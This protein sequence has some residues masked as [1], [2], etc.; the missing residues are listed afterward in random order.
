MHQAAM[1]KR[2]DKV[3]QK[4][5]VFL[6]GPPGSGKS[7][8][9]KKL[10]EQLGLPFYDLDDLIVARRAMSIEDIFTIF[11]EAEFRRIE[12]EVLQTT[13]AQTPG[14]VALGGGALLW[15]ANR[16]AA[17]FYGEVICLKAQPEIL[18][19]RIAHDGRIRPLLEGESKQQALS[20]L[21]HKRAS[22]YASFPL[23]LDTSH[24]PLESVVWHCQTLLGR[25]Y[26]RGMQREYEVRVTSGGLKTLGKLLQEH[27]L[28][29]PLAVVTDEHVAQIYAQETSE[30]L[31]GYGY[32]PEMVILPPGEEHKS[33]RSLQEVWQALVDMHMERWGTIVSL[34]GGVINDLAGFAAATYMR[35]VPW[36]AVPTTLLAMVDASIGGKTGIDL[37]AGKNLVGAFYAPRGVWIDP[38]SLRTL[39]REE[40]SNGMAEVI[41]HGVIGDVELFERCRSIETPAEQDW[42]EWVKHAVAVKIRVIQE[43]PF[44]EGRRAV[45]NLG[46]TLGHALEMLSGYTIRHGR[47]VAIGLVFAARLAAKMGIAH[48]DLAEQIAATLQQWDLP[49]EIPKHI[50]RQSILEAVSYDKKRRDGRPKWVLPAKIGEVIWGVD[51]PQHLLEEMLQA[52]L[53]ADEP[54]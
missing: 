22:H 41:K 14:V 1:Q 30:G 10:A 31:I 21:L 18:H 42:E 12:S 54:I 48:V 40:M 11:G 50:S 44:E 34:G 39:P 43:D 45:L 13:L 8:V 53:G 3:L 29:E 25:F 23:Q 28:R 38:Q 5:W 6:Y 46:H 4:D 26:V 49:T 32:N 27:G 20:T 51:V 33:L 7:A 35:G 9:G 15:E 2:K 37:R 52:E 16:H 47:A 24:L 36:V 19:E 17:E